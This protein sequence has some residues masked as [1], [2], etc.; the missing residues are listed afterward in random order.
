MALGLF[1][2]FVCF[3]FETESP[4][5]QDLPTSHS[6]AENDFEFLWPSLSLPSA[7]VRTPPACLCGPGDQTQNIVDT[8]QMLYQLN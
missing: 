6:I 7:Q 1:L 5:A 2:G 3:Y 4:V 8:R